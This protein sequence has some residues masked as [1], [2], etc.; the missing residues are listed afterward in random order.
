MIHEHQHH[1]A[2]NLWPYSVGLDAADAL[3]ASAAQEEDNQGVLDIHYHAWQPGHILLQ[4]PAYYYWVTKDYGKTF[5]AYQ[6]PG[7]QTLGFWMELKIHPR[8]PDWI[9]AKVR[10]KDCLVDASSNACAHD[11]FVSKVCTSSYSQLCWLSCCSLLDV[12]CCACNM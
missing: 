8:V 6:T 10:R 5:I 7:D 4:G 11:L 9:L 1:I 3:P 2:P 12:L